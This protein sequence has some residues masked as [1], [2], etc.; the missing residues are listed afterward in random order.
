[1]YIVITRAAR[2]PAELAAN[3]NKTRLILTIPRAMEAS[4]GIIFTHG[5][6]QN[7]LSEIQA[8]NS[9]QIYPTVDLCRIANYKFR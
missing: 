8:F 3:V 1:M 9:A 7:F 2:Q 4:F 6:Y 5:V